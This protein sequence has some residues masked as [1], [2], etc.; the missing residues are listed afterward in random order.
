MSINNGIIQSILFNNKIW[1]VIDAANWCLNHG[2]KVIE[3]D[4]GPGVYRFRQVSPLTLKR[5]GYN[6]Y[7]IVNAGYGIDFMIAY[8][9][10]VESDII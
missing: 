9:P 3:I 1:D 10:K 6:E 2:H 5:K 8:K 7:K 4:D